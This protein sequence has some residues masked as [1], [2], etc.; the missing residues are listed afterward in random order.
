MSGITSHHLTALR[1][2]RSHLE[3][4]LMQSIPSDD[5]IILG[6]IRDA[7]AELLRTIRA[8]ETEMQRSLLAQA[9]AA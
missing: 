6:H 2:A 5:P 7:S 1:D 3:A 8:L 4:A 9:V